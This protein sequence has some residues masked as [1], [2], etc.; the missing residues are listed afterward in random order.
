LV[1][2]ALSIVPDRSIS[3]G[4]ARGFAMTSSPLDAHRSLPEIPALDSATT[5][6]EAARALVD[7]VREAALERKLPAA[8]YLQALQAVGQMRG[9]SLAHPLLSGGT[10]TGAWVQLADGRRVLDM[11]SGIGPYVF[12]HDD[13]DLLETAAIAAAGDVVFQG[14]V[15]PG[16]EYAQL[17][18]RLLR[19]SGDRLEHVWLSLSGSMANEN[20]W[21][22]ILQKHAPADR[23]LVFEQAFHGRTLAMAELTDRPSYREGLPMRGNVHRVPFYDP[24]DPQSLERSLEAIDGAASAHPGRIAAMC[25][26][27]VQGEGG[28]NVAPPAFFEALMARC[29]A[30]GIAVWID[31]IQT[32]GRTGELFAFRTLGLESEVDVVTAGKI[33]H[34]SA[35]LFTEDYRPRPK[36]IAGTWAGASVGMAIGARILERLEVENYLGPNGGIVRLVERLDVAFAELSSRLP[37]VIGG[38]SGLGAMQAFVPWEGD[39]HQVAELIESCLEEGVLFQPAGSTPTKVRMLPPLNLTDDELE[40]AFAALERGIRR[41]ASRHGRSF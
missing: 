13:Q 37:G 4:P 28:F 12:G 10:G 40:F 7:A 3:A 9:Q 27:L 31:E 39:P 1:T 15:L 2:L 29:H 32:F 21:K 8:D 35:T 38:R 23:V 6:R 25:F 41:V 5:V 20:A 17:C 36:L 19:H 34:G 16:I 22:I 30:L 24:T 14:H 33:L 18:Q 26:E 11:V